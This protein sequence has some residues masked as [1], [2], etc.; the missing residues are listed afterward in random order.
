MTRAQI[1]DVSMAR[2]LARSTDRVAEQL[3]G[4][5]VRNP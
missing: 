1:L 3:V 4:W 2:S 5:L